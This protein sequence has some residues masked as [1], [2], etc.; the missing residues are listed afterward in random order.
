MLLNYSNEH[1]L[2]IEVEDAK[3]ILLFAIKVI[4]FGP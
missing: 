1:R 2:L 4:V 3:A